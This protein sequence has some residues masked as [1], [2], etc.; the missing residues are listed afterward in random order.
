MTIFDGGMKEIKDLLD[1]AGVSEDSR[2]KLHHRLEST[3]PEKHKALLELLGLKED[4]IKHVRE[5][6]LKAE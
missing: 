1:Y 6:A 2:W 3:K 5:W 4:E